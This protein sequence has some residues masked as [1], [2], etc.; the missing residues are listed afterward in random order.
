[1]KIWFKWIVIVCTVALVAVGVARSLATRKAQ[2]EALQ[3]Q[4]AAQ[5]TPG[6]VDLQSSEIATAQAVDLG[7]GLP[8]SGTIKA[9]HTALIK[10]R[11]PGEVQG[12]TVREGDYVRAGQVIAHIDDTEVKARVR[13]AQQ[14]VISAKA[15]VAIAQRSFD[16]N[17]SLVDQGFIS[18][19]ALD[20]STSNLAAAEANFLAATAAADLANK[21]LEDAVLRS[22]IAGQVAQRFAQ[23][24]ERVGVDARIIE[25][26]DLSQLELESSLSAADSLM[27]QVGQTAT[28]RIE[29][30][31]KDFSAKVNRINPSATLGNRAILVYLS[32]APGSGLR[33]GLFAQG[34][35][36]TGKVRG[37]AVPL[38]AVRTD[39]PQP[40][41][42][43]LDKGKVAHQT[44][45]MGARGMFNGLTWVVV[46][47]ISE[48][49]T[50]LLGTAGAL[51]EGT[52]VNVM[53][54]AK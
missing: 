7:Q 29:G 50:V 32:I 49:A 27:A 40:Y 9:V 20:T 8:L 39:K 10:A 5:K 34:L 51:R 48:N 44:V 26:V 53:N 12:L 4:L 19:T 23:P 17:R 45:T 38:S 16:N 11:I 54:S 42:Q 15:Q 46:D 47:G 37:L 22:P 1:M 33:Q 35:L 6:P 28:L 18:K 41:L 2:A 31:D 13:Q 24:N 3:A 30:L 14:Q 52:P 25:I 21:A 43:W 36:S